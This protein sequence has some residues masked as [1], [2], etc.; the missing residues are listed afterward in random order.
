MQQINENLLVLQPG[1]PYQ[2]VYENFLKIYLSGSLDL[3]VG[4][5]GLS[6][7]EKFINGLSKMTLPHPN[8]PNIPDYSKFRFLVFN[9]LVPVNGAPSID[10]PEFVQKSQWELNMM[11]SADV[12][13][14]NFLRKSTNLSA[15]SGFLL[16]AQSGKIVC[17]CPMDSMF[18]A[19]IKV[20]SDTFQIPLVGDTGSVISVMDTMF[21]VNQKF[22]QLLNYNL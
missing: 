18:Y 2:E 6:W 11:G 16:W 7:Q 8:E 9:P 3:G 4:K 5:P 15:I 20:I 10:N 17:R 14:C 22:N 19:Q 13:F 12:I 21:Q 1:D